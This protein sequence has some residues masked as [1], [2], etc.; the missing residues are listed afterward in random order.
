MSDVACLSQWKVLAVGAFSAGMCRHHLRQHMRFGRESSYISFIQTKVVE[1]AVGLHDSGQN[2]CGNW[3]LLLLSYE[4]GSINVIYCLL[5]TAMRPRH[6]S[7]R[8]RISSTGFRL[9]RSSL[10]VLVICAMQHNVYKLYDQLVLCWLLYQLQLFLNGTIGTDE[11]QGSSVTW[12]YMC[13]KLSCC[14]CHVH[15]DKSIVILKVP[16]SCRELMRSFGWGTADAFMQHDAQV[17]K[18]HSLK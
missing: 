11:Y 6:F 13:P 14:D 9:A 10:K 1:T 17:H 8:C 12:C 5:F 7:L 16:V 15:I 3:A 18:T 4:I 2:R